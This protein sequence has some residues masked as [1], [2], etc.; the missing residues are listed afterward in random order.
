MYLP[1]VSPNKNTMNKIIVAFSSGLILGLL[2]APAK[3]KNT[4]KKIANLGNSCKQGWNNVTDRIA[5][6]IERVKDKVDDMAYSAVEKI[7]G[8]QFD[9]QRETI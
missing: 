3:G 2:F 9:T 4:R 1:K 8:I 5:G 6:K 7:E